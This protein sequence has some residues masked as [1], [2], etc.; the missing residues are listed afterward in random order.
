M[1][2]LTTGKVLVYL[3]IIF[4]AG[5]ATGAVIMRN[6]HEHQ[7]Q[8]AS[9]EKAC[10]RFQ[11]RLVSKLS[12]TDVQVKKLQPVF[13]ETAQ[14]LRAVHARAIH[15]TDEII[16]KAHQQIAKELTPE[17]KAKLEQFDQERQEWLRQRLNEQA[18]TNE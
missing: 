16:R 6:A 12:L 1:N 13:D 7:A 15:H 14:E 4:M 8:P 17:Q 11:D 18:P 3:A 5:G 2:Y 9:M 10:H